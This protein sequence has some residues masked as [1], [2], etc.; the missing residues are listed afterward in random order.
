M[1]APAAAQINVGPSLQL[2]QPVAQDEAS[3][4]VTRAVV[5]TRRSL[6]LPA[7]P[8][9]NLLGLSLS[10]LESHLAAQSPPI[11]RYRAKQI[12]HAIYSSG[13]TSFD[14]IHTLPKQLRVELANKF[15]I[16]NGTLIHSQCS[17]IDYTRKFLIGFTSAK[18]TLM[19]YGKKTADGS[20]MCSSSPT[21]PSSAPSSIAPPLPLDR[22][23]S[24]YIPMGP[25]SD[26]ANA[27]EGSICVSCQVGC[28]LSCTFCATGSMDKKKLRNLT[29]GEILAQVLSIQHALGDFKRDKNDSSRAVTNIVFM[30]MGEPLYNYRHVSRAIDIL[31]SS[32]RV[33]GVGLGFGRGKI[34]LSTSGVV[35]AIDKLLN[36]FGGN[37]QLAV[38]LH[39]TNDALRSRI[40]P[41][42]DTYP[43][44]E[45]MAAVR[46]Y[47]NN[48]VSMTPVEEARD[49]N[50]HEDGAPNI[51]LSVGGRRRITFEYVMLSGVNDSL[52]DAHALVRLLDGIVALVNLIPFN[53][54]KG[55]PYVSS[56]PQHIRHFAQLLQQQ[57]LACTIR[58]PRGRDIDGACGQLA[59][60]EEEASAHA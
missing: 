5:S 15:D 16:G 47:Q 20:G 4:P 36:D 1:L 31:T 49:R 52:A 8:R 32:S 19:Q 26:Y 45:L 14:S 56:S 55:S 3:T 38:S 41:I 22:I 21:P 9:I 11:P 34:T 58:W 7:A 48:R 6:A 42:N 57:G 51:P 27:R 53:P 30:G 39:G 13:A 50:R 12:L 23:E 60:K 35:P 24:V 37:V 59:I 28:S 2:V 46:R 17:Q 29:S 10:E 44:A 25:P 33:G 54:W 43:L 40:M 18:Q